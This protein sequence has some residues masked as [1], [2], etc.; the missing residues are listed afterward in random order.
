LKPLPP[1][2]LAAWRAALGDEQV[3]VDPISRGRNWDLGSRVPPVDGAV[4]LDLGRTARILMS[5]TEVVSYAIMPETDG[6]L[7]AFL[8][9]VGSP[10]RRGH[11]G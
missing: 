10:V 6:R 7:E 11:D 2:A 1:E 8:V 4:L 9:K 5:D 3:V